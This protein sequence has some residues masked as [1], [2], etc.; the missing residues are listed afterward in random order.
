[1]MGPTAC[2]VYAPVP[3]TSHYVPTCDPPSHVSVVPAR[4]TIKL[5]EQQSFVDVDGLNI[6]K[7]T[8]MD[9]D[10]YFSDL[11]YSLCE[12]VS[13]MHTHIHHCLQM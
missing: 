7:H 10:M 11:G 2:T 6:T 1:M 13:L 5:K 4:K 3:G 8:Q 12:I 9:T